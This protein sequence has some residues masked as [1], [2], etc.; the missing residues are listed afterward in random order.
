M[1]RSTTSMYMSEYIP[2]L[3]PVGIIKQGFVVGILETP[4]GTWHMAHGTW[5]MAHGTW[6]M[7][8]RRLHDK[9]LTSKIG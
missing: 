2:S 9:D 5:H 6:H 3:A 8:H 4:N 1:L 7:A